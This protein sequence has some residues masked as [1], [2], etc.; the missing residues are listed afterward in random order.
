MS[1]PDRIHAN[2]D[3]GMVGTGRWKSAGLE[4]PFGEW[5]YLSDTPARRHAEELADH[6]RL[7][8]SGN[9]N[10]TEVL[11]SARATLAKLEKEDG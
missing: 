4:N 11:S 1:R 7:L 8:L 3:K 2:P 5:V 6:L 10:T 9:Y